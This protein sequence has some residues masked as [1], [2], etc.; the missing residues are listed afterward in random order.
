MR[1]FALEHPRYLIVFI[2][3]AFIIS[4][5]GCG[6][7]TTP[8][9]AAII[10]TSAPGMNIAYL[11]RKEGLT[12]LFVDDVK[13]GHSSRGS[14]STDNPVHTSVVSAGDPESGGY[15]CQVETKDGK[16][17]N[18]RI[19]GKEYDLSK[20]TLFVIKANGKHVE[21]HQLKRDLT[22][23]PF[24]ADGCREPLQKDTEIR[25]LLGLSELPK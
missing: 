21:V 13:G 11:Q 4:V 14:G 19:N 10:G 1:S 18:C 24:D 5:D 23:I 12:V 3:F 16:S 7:R 22:T 20:G 25:K 8:P 2:G 17:A 9:G 15:K 6:T